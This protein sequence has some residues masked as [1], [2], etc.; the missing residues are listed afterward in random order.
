MGIIAS[1]KCRGRGVGTALMKAVVDLGKN[2]FKLHDI[3]LVVFSSNRAIHLYERFGFIE[4]GRHPKWLKKPT[5]EYI[6]RIFMRL[7]LDK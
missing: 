5:G 7:E 3:N 2:D 6:D 1:P 4:F